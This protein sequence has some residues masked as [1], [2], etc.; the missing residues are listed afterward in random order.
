[1]W[2]LRNRNKVGWKCVWNGMTKSERE[3]ASSSKLLKVVHV[4]H[5]IATWA[6]IISHWVWLCHM[7]TDRLHARTHVLAQNAFDWIYANPFRS[8]WN[9]RSILS[10]N[11]TFFSPSIFRHRCIFFFSPF[12]NVYRLQFVNLAAYCSFARSFA[13][14]EVCERVCVYVPTFVSSF[15]SC[16]H[17]FIY[18]FL[19]HVLLLLLSFSSKKKEFH[20]IPWASLN[21]IQLIHILY[22]FL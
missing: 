8:I 4:R 11:D 22:I 14:G 15:F 5:C 3:R 7:S 19:M 6:N 2:M 16:I 9:S 10:T 1:M 17:N 12:K 21:C 20:S 13:F 18:V